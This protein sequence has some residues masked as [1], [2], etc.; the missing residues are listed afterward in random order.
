MR[1]KIVFVLV[2]FLYAFPFII[3]F[4]PI[5]KSLYVFL[6]FLLSLG[7][8]S[9]IKLNK[10]IRLLIASISIFFV[11]ALSLLYSSEPL[12]GIKMLETKLGMIVIPLSFLLF[13]NDKQ[14]AD[15]LC[16]N[17]LSINFLYSS[18]LYSLTLFIYFFIYTDSKYP[19]IYTSG[20]FQSAAKNFPLIGEHHIY[21]SLILAASMLFFLGMVQVLQ[22]KIKTIEVLATLIVLIILWVLQSR[23]ILI[24]LIIVLLFLYGERLK[25]FK[26]KKI[27]FMS[28]IVS[29]V[30]FLTPQGNNRF[31]ELTNYFD[32]DKQNSASQRLVI[33]DCSWDLLIKNP[34]KGVGV[35]TTQKLLKNCFNEKTGDNSRSSINT[36]NQYLDLY[37]TIGPWGLLLFFWLKHEILNI[38]KTSVNKRMILSVFLF[39][40]IALIFENFFE[41]QTGVIFIYFFTFFLIKRCIEKN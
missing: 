23:T 10:G 36:H 35:G 17:K 32:Y 39:F 41:R 24:S 4:P 19:N 1:N 21:I 38:I 34:T 6:F 13:L 12:V 15:R 18:A 11:Y 29:C 3:F 2:K 25:K 7:A 33:Y 37:I 16:Y 5:V 40:S 14:V 8:W 27:I 22:R 26:I 20:F 30:F 28:F 9:S 31:L